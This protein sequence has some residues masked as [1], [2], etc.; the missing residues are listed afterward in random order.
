MGPNSG[1]AVLFTKSMCKKGAT[2]CIHQSMHID[3]TNERH[4][5]R[6]PESDRPAYK[7]GK[8]EKRKGNNRDANRQAR[9]AY[10]HE[11]ATASGAKVI[12]PLVPTGYGG[13]V[14]YTGK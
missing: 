14:R 12:A 3:G 6:S 8:T 13:L 2:G 5:H 1:E 4:F 10:N 11:V 7:T 9:A